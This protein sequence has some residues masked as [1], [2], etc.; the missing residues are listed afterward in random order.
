MPP[1]APKP[2]EP[3]THPSPLDDGLLRIARSLVRKEERRLAEAAQ[4]G[5]VANLLMPPDVCRRYLIGECPAD[6]QCGLQHRVPQE[7]HRFAARAK[8]AEASRAASGG[9]AEA[10]PPSPVTATPPQERDESHRGGSDSKSP[11]TAAPQ[12]ARA[13]NVPLPPA[14]VLPAGAPRPSARP[15]LHALPAHPTARPPP[16]AALKALFDEDGDTATCL[17]LLIGPSPALT[18]SFAS[19]ALQQTLLGGTTATASVQ[20]AFKAPGVHV[21]SCESR[22]ACAPVRRLVCAWAPRTHAEDAVRNSGVAAVAAAADAVVLLFHSRTEAVALPRSLAA[23]KGEKAPGGDHAAR[24]AELLEARSEVGDGRPLSVVVVVKDAGWDAQREV[25]EPTVWG[26]DTLFRRW[27][28]TTPSNPFTTRSATPCSRSSVREAR[29]AA[30]GS[31]S[32]LSGQRPTSCRQAPPFSS[33]R[34]CGSET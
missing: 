4:A 7:F 5:Q 6:G 34:R 1:K 18:H 20:C 24:L 33:R 27:T 2:R 10:V 31:M 8:D 11:V 32:R 30:S 14:A 15:L 19:R 22:A 13:S 23:T 3:P 25:C 21:Q 9:S 28:A 29:R 12:R 16:A 17:V 26:P